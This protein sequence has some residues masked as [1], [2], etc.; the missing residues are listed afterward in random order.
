MVVPLPLAHLVRRVALGMLSVAL[1]TVIQIARF[2]TIHKQPQ[3][4]SNNS[5][6]L[7]PDSYIT[8]R[9]ALLVELLLDWEG[10]FN[11]SSRTL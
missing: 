8:I 4:N 7:A 11:N 9:W 10:R 1:C 3:V 2:S 6:A 5:K